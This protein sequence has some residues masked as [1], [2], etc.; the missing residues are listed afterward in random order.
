MKLI[1]NGRRSWQLLWL[2]HLL[3]VPGVLAIQNGAEVQAQAPDVATVAGP[4]NA[5]DLQVSEV[6]GIPA[7]DCGHVMERLM[8]QRLRLQSGQGAGGGHVPGFDAAQDFGDLELLGVRLVAEGGP[9]QGPVIQVSLRNNSR[10]PADRLY[11]SLVAVLERIHLHSPTVVLPVS[12]CDA[13][14]VLHLAVQL[15]ASSMSLTSATGV[16]APFDTLVVVLDSFDCFPECNE[17]NNLAILK[18]G[19]LYPPPMPAAAAAVP[20]LATVG[21]PAASPVPRSAP[22]A[23]HEALPSPPSAPIDLDELDLDSASA[24]PDTGGAG[25]SDLAV[26]Q[27]ADPNS[28]GAPPAGPQT[29]APGATAGVPVAPQGVPADPQPVQ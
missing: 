13:G 12:R 9:A 2:W 8:M 18:R 21:V 5:A 27:P 24:E 4:L 25:P 16:A 23:R 20:G 17:L 19:Q 6:L 3:T 26:P 7:A 15:P 10:Y 29:A 28:A 1:P 14:A 22:A 11:I